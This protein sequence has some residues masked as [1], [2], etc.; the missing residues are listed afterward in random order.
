M[1]DLSV[2]IANWNTCDLLARCLRAVYDTTSHLDL[3]VIV[4]DNASTD[5]SQEM[6]R[7]EFPGV[8][9]IA[10]TENLG[11][12]KANNQAIRRSQ[13]RY[14]LLLNSDTFVG[15]HTI[16]QMVAFMDSHPEAGIA[17]CKLLYGDGRLQ[18]SCTSFPTLFTELCIATHLDKLFPTSSLFGRYLMTYWDFD[19]VR[20][21]DVILGAFMLARAPAVGEVGLLDERYFMYSEE[22]DWCYRFKQKGWK[23]YFYPFVSAV[24]LWG[25]SIKRIRVEMLVQM[26]RSRTDFFRQCYGR[27]SAILLKLLVGLG[28]LFRIGPGAWHYLRT[29][30]PQTRQ[31]WQAYWRLLRALPTL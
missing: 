28:C 3:E 9:L 31:K 4:V 22:V 1:T 30:D 27:S 17:G 19:D 11:F 24:H 25:G 8:S 18:R 12:A 26:Y 2:V 6:V 29:D 5:G 20:E 14:V 13:G 10:N 23:V 21:V 15:E 16:E 7:Q